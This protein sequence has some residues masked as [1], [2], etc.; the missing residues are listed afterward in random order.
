MMPFN[1]TID[2]S[3]KHVLSVPIVFY[4][5]WRSILYFVGFSRASYFKSKVKK[6]GTCLQFWRAEKRFRFWIRNSVKS[7]QFY[8]FV[9]VLVFFNTVCVAVEHYNQPQW[10]TDFLC[11]C[12][13]SILTYHY[14]I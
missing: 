9:I 2:W 13:C 10:L 11:K 14:S 8:W 1:L 12:F 6:Q 7:Q 3:V 4:I 5:R